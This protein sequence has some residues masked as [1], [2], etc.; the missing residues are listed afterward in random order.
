MPYIRT[1][2]TEANTRRAAKGDPF[3]GW[4]RDKAE[5]KK[6]APTGWT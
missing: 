3:R 5:P 6:T 2:G 4:N 1:E